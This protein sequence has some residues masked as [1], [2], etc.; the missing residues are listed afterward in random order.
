[1]FNSYNTFENPPPIETIDNIMLDFDNVN[2]Y[3]MNKWLKYI[4]ESCSY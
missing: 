2:K 4:Q 3:Q 1:M